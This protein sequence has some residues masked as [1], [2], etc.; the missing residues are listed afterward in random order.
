MSQKSV[1][2]ALTVAI[3]LYAMTVEAEAKRKSERT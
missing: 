1:L 3:V 2:I